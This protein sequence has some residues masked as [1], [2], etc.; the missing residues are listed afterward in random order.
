MR[1]CAFLK[2]SPVWLEPDPRS[3]K[4]GFHFAFFDLYEPEF[5]DRTVPHYV[6]LNQNWRVK[7][8]GSSGS[9]D[10]TIDVN[11]LGY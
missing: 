11:E 7:H 10:K 2:K 3:G 9:P 6:L 1:P 4:Q 5:T 8:W